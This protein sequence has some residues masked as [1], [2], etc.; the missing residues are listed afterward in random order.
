[1]K[2]AKNIGIWMDHSSAH[3]IDLTSDP[4]E[5][6]LITSQF[7]QHTKEE[8]ILKGEGMMHT[9][10]QH[11]QSEYYHHVA[12]VIRNYDHVLLFGPSDAKSELHNIIK[13][14]PLFSKIRIDVKQA[15]KMNEF[16]QQLFV[17]EYFDHPD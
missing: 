9:K 1:M 12:H 7:F 11:Q 14:D 10:E 16:Q 6:K 13:V 15:D 2:T 3:L 17:K 4:V 5:N 8:R